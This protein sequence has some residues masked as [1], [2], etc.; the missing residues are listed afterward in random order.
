MA[1]DMY[2]DIADSI[3]EAAKA[4]R[5]RRAR[6]IFPY[7][8]LI[9]AA[10]FVIGLMLLPI[11]ATIYHSFTNW[12]GLTSTFIG[13]LNF[14][15]IIH[16]PIV[17]E[18]FVNSLIFLIS[19]PL[20]LIASLVVA[21]FVYEKVPGWR[22]FR[23]LFFIPN[24]LSPVIVGVLFSTFFLPGSPISRCGPWGSDRSPGCPIRGR[25]AW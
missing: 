11:G 14:S 23:F 10:L 2:E 3:S 5:P 4:P 25:R 18:I 12:D 22:L 7:L 19:V 13:W 9:P 6:R 24:V 17:S 8:A 1:A 15:L 21:V 20:I 16:N